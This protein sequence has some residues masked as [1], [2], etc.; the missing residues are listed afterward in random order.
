MRS[1]TF[2]APGTLRF[3]EV[4]APTILDPGDALVR[5][6][7]ATTCDLDHHVIAD[8]TPFSMA[9]PFAL[10]HE[11]VGTVVE[12]GSE[13]TDFAIGDVVGVAWHIAC[14]T[15]AQCRINHPARCL[16]Y[17]DAQY[18]LP[19][20]GLW[21]G[22]FSELIRVPFADYNLAPLP[23]GVDPV[24]LASIGD[25]L[26][27]GWE[28]VVPTVAEIA[29][30]RVAVFGGTGSIGLYCVDAAV[31]CAG[32]HTVYY[33]DDPVRMAVAEQLGA[34]VAD[35]NGKREKNFDL[36][37]DASA[38]PERL[39]MALR[40]VMPEGHVNSVGIYFQD[41]ASPMLQLY[42]RGVHFHN[43]KGHARPSMT[44]TLDAVAAN[45]LHPQLVTSGIYGWDEMPEVLTSKQA[46]HKPIFVL[47]ASGH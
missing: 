30:P 26:A 43:G 21:G 36:A 3:D 18:G 15:C 12:V 47:D 17:G 42:M 44:P 11:C 10:G 28:V 2:V 9:A 27:L 34:E 22:T 25:N 13:C 45:V 38:D 29:D 14:G 32:A 1:L 16:R 20:N 4:D 31:H 5:P 37:V 24:H 41:V 40:S 8:K 6:L 19:V 39:K 35:I 33:D 46:G 7:A 23:A